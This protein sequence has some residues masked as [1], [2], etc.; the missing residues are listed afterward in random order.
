MKVRETEIELLRIVVMILI[1]TT[2]L[3]VWGITKTDNATPLQQNTAELTN[4]VIRW[5]VNVFIIITGYFGIK[6]RKSLIN[7]I[8]ISLFYTWLLYG[9]QYAL[10]GDNFSFLP[11]IKSLFFVTHCRY[12]FV[13]S[14]ILLIILAPFINK[15]IDKKHIYTLL[16]SFLFI[17]CW[18]GYIHN[19]TISNGFGIL[20][21]TTMYIIGRSIPLLNINYNRVFLIIAFCIISILIIFQSFYFKDL[22]SSHGYNN[23]LLVIN[24]TIV[25]LLFKKIII[26]NNFIN[27]IAASSFAVYLIHDSEFAHY[28]LLRIMTTTNSYILNPISYL[29]AL[30]ILS[31]LIYF[32]CAISDKVLSYIYNPIIRILS[33]KYINKI[34]GKNY[35]ISS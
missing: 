27:T 34:E 14:Y 5:H 7:I 23:P 10:C 33:N 6:S 13:Q 17:D 18:C 25:F 3:V 28:W 29:F 11:I 31:V 2:H 12:W 1:I 8:I 4:A 22:I 16:G 32:I 30:I 26:K 9:L 20:H 35:D 19:E 21:F 15:L 24:A